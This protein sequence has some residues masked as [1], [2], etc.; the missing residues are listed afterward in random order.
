MS[1]LQR[2]IDSLPKPQKSTGKNPASKTFLAKP[3]HFADSWADRP[4][5][6]ILLGIRVPSEREIQGARTESIKI[7]RNVQHEDDAPQDEINQAKLTAFNDAL[8]ACAVASAL[9]DPNDVTAAHPFFDMPDDMV[10][11]AFKSKTIQHIFDLIEQLHVEQSP[12]FEEITEAEE[13]KLSNLLSEDAPYAGVERV[14]AMKARR[15][16]KFALDILEE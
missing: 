10:P 7:A 6:G 15:F 12:V 8:L 16:L 1:A 2:A 11:V 5:D 3:E 13:I 14:Q 4:V 9:C